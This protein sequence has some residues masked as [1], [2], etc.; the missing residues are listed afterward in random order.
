MLLNGKR[1][2]FQIWVQVLLHLQAPSRVH[3]EPSVGLDYAKRG[4]G[5]DLPD[6]RRRRRQYVTQLTY[7]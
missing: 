1:S 3:L 6:R 2:A 5:Q 7:R 4:R